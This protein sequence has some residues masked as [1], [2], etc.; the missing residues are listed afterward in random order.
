MLN[1]TS[2]ILTEKE[3]II[4]NDI[5]TTQYEKIIESSLKY[6]I[7]SIPFTINRMDIGNIEQRI[8]NI[9][10]GKIAEALFKEYCKRIGIEIS[11]KECITP[12][13]KPDKRDFILNG[14][15]WDIKNNFIYHDK[16]V[17]EISEYL[18]LPALI[19]NRGFWD[20][21]GKKDRKFIAESKGVK[22]L[23]TFLKNL[24][25]YQKDRNFI[26][27]VLTQNQKL[28]I[29]AIYEK[30]KSLKFDYAPYTENWYWNEFFTVSDLKQILYS[31]V[32]YPKL[33]ITG[34]AD[35]KS[36]GKFVDLPPTRI[37]NGAMKTTI[38]N[39]ACRIGKLPSFSS[40][41]KV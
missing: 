32:H 6:A 18:K 19:P 16:D 8:I 31:V 28:F 27:L 7:I 41:I 17:L 10:K 30:H 15:E 22:F 25:F 38:E 34:F 21:W 14:F 9:T 11:D 3:I 36:W 35:E 23:F 1:L 13:Y 40:Y 24:D 29:L 4:F 20:Q 33:I 37:S 5:E 2:I 39:K 12:F 26:N